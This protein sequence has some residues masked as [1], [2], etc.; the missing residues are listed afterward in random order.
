LHWCESLDQFLAEEGIRETT[1]T[2]ALIRVVA[3]SLAQE[4]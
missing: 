1:R 4:A 3:W 2:E